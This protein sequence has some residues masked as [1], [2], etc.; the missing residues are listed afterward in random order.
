MFSET[1]SYSAAFAA[2]LLSFFS[3]C[4]LPLIPAY[5]SFITGMSLEDLTEK[6]S[7]AI[8]RKVFISTVAFILGFS[9]VFVLLG[10]SAS[11]LGSLT[12]AYRDP[13]RIAGGI[14]IIVLGIHLTGIVR[15]PFLEFEKR[16]H[17]KT[18][19][20]NIFGTFL[21]GMAFGAG[22]S[23]CTGP[24]LGSILAIAMGK[25]TV[26]QGVVLLGIYSAGLALPFIII[27]VFINYLLVFVKKATGFMKVFN[28]VAGAVLILAGCL[29]LA[30]KL[31]L[32]TAIG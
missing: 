19:P 11:Y 20:L 15:I 1:V 25:D 8:R 17:L 10:A 26:R 9:L 22:W 7:A 24:Q 3:P 4:V 23:P 5:F 21:V 6:Y 13:I 12:N 27:S 2:G 32:L 14:I 28:T 16:I 29:L 30:N 31:Y 18:K